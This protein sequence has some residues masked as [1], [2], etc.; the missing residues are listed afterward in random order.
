[1]KITSTIL[2][3]IVLLV[4]CGDNKQPTDATLRAGLVGTWNVKVI[5]ADGSSDTHG[6]FTVM[7]D[8]GYRSE[9]VTVVSNESRPVTLQGFIRVQD[10]FLIET[11]TNAIPHWL[12]E[13]KRGT[14]PPG[15]TVSRSKI[16]RLD[17]HQFVIETNQF[18]SV[19]Y[20]R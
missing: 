4:A 9:L 15:G 12:P 13:A 18:G 16:V 10:G 20:T 8:D 14:L 17:E 1:M 7:S 19:L 11:T 5:G 3:L 6:T 2:A